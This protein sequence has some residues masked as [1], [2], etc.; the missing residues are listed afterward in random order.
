MNPRISYASVA[1]RGVLAPVF[2]PVFVPAPG[3]PAPRPSLLAPRAS[4]LALT[5]VE[6]LIGMAITLLMMA[7]IVNLFANIGSGVRIRRAAMEM[8]GQLRLVRATLFNDLAGATCR[9]LPWHR[10]YEDAGYIEIIEG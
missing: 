1:S 4:R 3:N 7:A 6:M 2:A 5:L 9:A 10:E 8:G